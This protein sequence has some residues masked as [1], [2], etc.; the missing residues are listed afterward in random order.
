MIKIGNE[1]EIDLKGVS[2]KS[3]LI[4]IVPNLLI[5]I[6]TKSIYKIVGVI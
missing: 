4:G 3:K 6:G 5:V 2:G 1:H